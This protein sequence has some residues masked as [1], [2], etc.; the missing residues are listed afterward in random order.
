MDSN[1]SRLHKPTQV[2]HISLGL[3]VCRSLQWRHTNSH[4]YNN[5]SSSNV[6]RGVS[7]QRTNMSQSFTVGISQRKDAASDGPSEAKE[8]IRSKW[9][10][11]QWAFSPYSCNIQDCTVNWPWMVI[12][13]LTGHILMECPFLLTRMVENEDSG[14]LNSVSWQRKRRVEARNS[15]E[16]NQSSQFSLVWSYQTI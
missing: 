15:W 8:A 1:Q 7:S 14:R 6:R 4:Y 3:L 10:F 16:E 2:C 9:D 11:S 5:S 13:W 12:V